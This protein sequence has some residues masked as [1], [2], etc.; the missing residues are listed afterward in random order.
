[1]TSEHNPNANNGGTGS[2]IISEDYMLNRQGIGVN[3]QYA[4][5][6]QILPAHLHA[7]DEELYLVLQNP[8]IPPIPYH[9]KHNSPHKN[10]KNKVKKNKHK[11]L[12]SHSNLNI[13]TNINSNRNLNSNLNTSPNNN[14]NVNTPKRHSIKK[15]NS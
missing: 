8:P 15:N 9:S 5:Y 10:K 12:H 3:I 6:G 11:L 7:S 14:N 2:F 4:N 1:M 13:N